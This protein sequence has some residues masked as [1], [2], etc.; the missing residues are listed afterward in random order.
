MYLISK[1]Y[2]NIDVVVC[3]SRIESLSIVVIEA[4]ARG[5]PSIVSNSAGVSE[6][7]T[8]GINGWIFASGNIN[9]LEEKMVFAIEN[10]EVTAQV[11]RRSRNLYIKHFT[12]EVFTKNLL[13]IID[14]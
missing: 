14:A 10:R 3:P 4:M 5:I 11:G 13:R 12:K 6:Y 7:I 8:D 1:I 2:N 9:E